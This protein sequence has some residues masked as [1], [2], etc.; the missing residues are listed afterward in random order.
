VPF[1]PN[2]APHSRRL[3]LDPNGPIREEKRTS[4]PR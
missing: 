3:V 2:S 1:F 4:L